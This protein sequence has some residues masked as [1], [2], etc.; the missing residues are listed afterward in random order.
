[1]Q[2]QDTG[3][4]MACYRESAPV[5]LRKGGQAGM[6]CGLVFSFSASL[7]SFLRKR[8]SIP[9]LLTTRY[10]L[11]ATVHYPPG[12]QSKVYGLRSKILDACFR[13]HDA[14]AG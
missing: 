1:M 7:F 12:L 5:L 3:K 2:S 13:R 11:L 8:E 6:T 14:Q 4:L 9:S 10:Y